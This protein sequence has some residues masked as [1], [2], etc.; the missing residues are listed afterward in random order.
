MPTRRTWPAQSPRL[1]IFI[2]A[3]SSPLLPLRPTSSAGEPP[4]KR[5]WL[6]VRGSAYMLQRNMP[7]AI[8]DLTAAIE[9]SPDNSLDYVIRATAYEMNG[10][11]EAAVADISKAQE[12]GETKSFLYVA[13]GR[14]LMKLA[15]YD[16]ALADFDRAISKNPILASAY[17][18]KAMLLAACPDDT[19]RDGVQALQCATRGYELSDKKSI[20]LSAQAA[21][22]AECQNWESAIDLQTRALEAAPEADDRAEC[23]QRLALYNAHVPFR[24]TADE[25]ER[26]RLAL[27]SR[28]QKTPLIQFKIID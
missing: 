17:Y 10:N 16:E 6:F 26:A 21:A 19:K 8:E 13:R 15:R 14:A 2:T 22:Q 25:I 4:S 20:Y 5:D 7:K 11:Y 12:L 9:L 18:A 27:L 1:F 28:R 24:E 3:F 23:K